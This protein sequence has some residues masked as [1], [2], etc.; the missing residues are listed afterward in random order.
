MAAHVVLIR[1]G[2]TEWSRVRR[3]T[4]ITELPLTDVGRA[5]SEAI[6]RGLTSWSFSL[7]LVSPRQRA[8]ETASIALPGARVVVN[9]DLAEWNYGQYEGLT[10]DEIHAKNPTW[11]L[12]R[13]GCPGGESP[14]DV[15]ARADR[16]IAIT[17]DIEGDVAC[18]AHAHILRVIGARWIGLGPDGGAVLDLNTA[19]MSVLGRERRNRVI[20]RW[21]V[22]TGPTA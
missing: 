18:F 22:G 16:V 5:E 10:T 1:H 3:H 6:G 21:N 7:V 4:S 14:S 12:W 8:Q 13:D 15:A 2:E 17:Q 9:P 19:T 11:N 20:Q